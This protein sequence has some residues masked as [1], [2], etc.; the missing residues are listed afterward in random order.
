MALTVIQEK[1]GQI[2]KLK[3]NRN[4]KKTLALFSSLLILAGLKAQ[5]TPA[6]AVKKET[7]KPVITI[8]VVT[9]T[10]N[11]VKLATT[12]KQTKKQ[13][14]LTTLKRELLCK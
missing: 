6:P 8:P 10:V 12:I 4:M 14:S 11:T 9:D 13:L 1:N 5:T 3:N 2:F 7:V